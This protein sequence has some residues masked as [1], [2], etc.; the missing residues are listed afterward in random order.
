[1]FNFIIWLVI[2]LLPSLFWIWFFIRYDW[3]KPEP[4]KIIFKVFILAIIFSS[5]VLLFRY[6]GWTQI[7]EGIFAN[8]LLNQLFYLFILVA[9]FEEG[10]KF[11]AVIVGAYF[12]KAYDEHLDGIIY[13]VTAGLGVAAFENF[14]SVVAFGGR[15]VLFRFATSTLMHALVGGIM[16][17][18]MAKA[19]FERKN[20]ICIFEG[21]IVAVILHGVYNYV[22]KFQ[23]QFGLIYLSLV[24]IAMFVLLMILIKKAKHK[25]I[26]LTQPFDGFGKLTAGKLRD[27]ILN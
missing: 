4:P 14:M 11:L 26:S 6:L 2:S 23:N 22:L 10:I 13:G 15:A 25:K 12:N 8:L 24:L 19:K 27:R 18:F 7:F 1:M 21:L 17:Y 5:I 16:G 20:K 3:E 9:F